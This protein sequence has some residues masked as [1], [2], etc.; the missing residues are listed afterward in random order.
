M[1]TI[2]RSL[3]FG[4]I[5]AALFALGAV[6]GVAQDACSDGPGL[7]AASGKVRQDFTDYGKMQPAD[8]HK[9]I[10]NAK[11]FV[12]K[13]GACEPAK[14]LVAYINQ[15][16]PAMESALKKFE[17]LQ[18]VKGKEARFNTAAKA[19]PVNPDELF[20]AGKDLLAANPEDYRPVELALASVA[21]DDAYKT[22]A[23]GKYTEESLRYGRQAIA[24][25]ESDKKF[26][27]F[28]LGGT[29]SFTDKN[30]ALAWMNM[31]VGYLSY[32]KNKKD[33]LPY[34]YKAAQ[35]TSSTAAKDA[36]ELIGDYYRDEARKLTKD[37]ID[38]AATLKANTTATQ[39]QIKAGNDEIDAKNALALGYA[40]RA[41]DA[42]ARATKLVKDPAGQAA[43]KKKFSDIYSF[44]FEKTD[45]M[46]A[47]I[48]A[49]VAKPFP[50]PMTDV[51]PVVTPATTAPG[52]TSVVTNLGAANGT[53]IGAANGTGIGAAN[54]TG[55]GAA[56]GTGVGAA[57]G[58]S[59]TT[60]TKPATTPAAKPTA[61]KKPGTSKTT[62][63]V[64]KKK[65]G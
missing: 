27:T 53:G 23:L 13:Y 10:D 40:E 45:G 25:L 22:R 60:T 29:Y 59:T 19:T 63:A 44:R 4:L 43:M 57:K 3:N 54:G 51:Q 33:G 8:K 65:N 55:I 17:D 2:F 56:T 11:A 15:Y 14:D 26:S 48:A 30:D 42:Y 6:A 35:I 61:A 18:V 28:N 32:L 58:T 50:N 62:V 46:D 52:G 5:L 41:L 36:T 47:W 24:D 31:S 20:A 9:A 7:E 12:E 21:F 34:L 64:K 16:L 37:A 49:A 39:D 38:L 1:K